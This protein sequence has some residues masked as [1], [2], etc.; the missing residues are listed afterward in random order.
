MR[1]SI[2]L[3]GR[4]VGEIDPSKTDTNSLGEKVPPETIS[5]KK[6]LPKMFGKVSEF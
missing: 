3:L 6:L 4:K 2:Q 5:E 1:K